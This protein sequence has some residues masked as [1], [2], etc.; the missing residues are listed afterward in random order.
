MTL[1]ATR[2]VESSSQG[3]WG[4]ICSTFLSSTFGFALGIMKSQLMQD[5]FVFVVGIFV[6]VLFWVCLVFCFRLLGY[7]F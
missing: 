6:V 1:S 3:A 2:R 4:W 5:S 7:F